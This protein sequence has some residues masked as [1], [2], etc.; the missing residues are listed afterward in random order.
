M[1]NIPEKRKTTTNNQNDIPN[2]AN[3]Q[4]VNNIPRRKPKSVFI[5]YIQGFS[6]KLQKIYKKYNI[7]TIHK[8]YNTLKELLVHPKDPTEDLD[9]CGVIYRIDCEQCDNFYIRESARKLRVK[10]NEHQTRNASA[11]KAHFQETGHT[12]RPDKVQIICRE[13]NT[14]LRKTKESIEIRQFNPQL[15]RYDG[16]QLPNIYNPLLK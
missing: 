6:E 1:F 4:P 5:P 14:S 13:D 3:P 10:I 12:I 9:K 15:N 11:I 8:P 7:N 2:D 16:N